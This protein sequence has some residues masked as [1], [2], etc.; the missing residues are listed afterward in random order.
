MAIK[1]L[2]LL[3]DPFIERAVLL[4][5]AMSPAYDLA[6]A[7]RAVRTEII[8]FWSPLDVLVL[9]AGTRWFGTIDRVKTVSAGLVG[10]QV[11]PEQAR[12]REYGKLRQIRWHPRMAATGYFGGHWGPDSPWFL[13]KYIIPLLRV[14]KTTPC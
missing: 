13:R 10:F 5:P 11:S 3:D 14:E 6:G 12:S 8:V 1:A 4:A 2:E 9:G 7:L